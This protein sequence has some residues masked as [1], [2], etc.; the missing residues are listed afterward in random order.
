MSYC[1][2]SQQSW[3]LLVPLSSFY[4]PPLTTWR[5]GSTK[6]TWSAQQQAAL[7]QVGRQICSSLTRILCRRCWRQRGL[8]HWR[9][10]PPPPGTCAMPRRA[11]RCGR[12]TARGAGCIHISTC[13]QARPG[14]T[15]DSA[16]VLA[17]LFVNFEATCTLSISEQLVITAVTF[18]AA[19]SPCS[20]AQSS[21]QED[22]WLAGLLLVSVDHALP[23]PQPIHCCSERMQAGG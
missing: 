5:T 2:R 4:R 1:N 19:A 13:L 21:L 22:R 8:Q 14:L 17:C 18:T 11:S 23:D 12:R 3:A 7:G 20:L 6:Q 9:L 16:Q 15:A 10:Q